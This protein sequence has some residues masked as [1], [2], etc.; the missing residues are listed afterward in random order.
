MNFTNHEFIV[1]EI[2]KHFSILKNDVNAVQPYICVSS[3][4]LVAICHFLKTNPNLYFD[5]LNSITGIDQGPDKGIFEIWYTLTSITKELSFHLK[6]ELNRPESLTE[7]AV[8]PS[9]SSIW[10]TAEWHE[11]EIYDLL[12]VKFENHPDLRRILLPADWVG[13][14]LRKD[15]KE[16]AQY[17]DLPIQY[18]R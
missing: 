16:A 7:L 10:R 5:F 6:I 4:L 13:F 2:E 3:E 8:A 1:G 9:I 14:P 18:D 12:G 17:H 15:Y 11:R